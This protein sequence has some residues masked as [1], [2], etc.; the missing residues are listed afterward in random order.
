MIKICGYS[1]EHNK[2]GVC[3]ITNCDK[4]IIMTT[5]TSLLG[6][7]AVEPQV[8]TRWQ[9]PTI[10]DLKKE[11]NKL[12][13]ES[14]EWEERTY[15]WQDRAENLQIVLDKIKEYI[16]NNKYKKMGGYGDNEDEDIEICLFED[17]IWKLEELLEEIE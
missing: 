7:S 2:G 1:C 13:A 5:T 14:T 15:C 4:K 8:L 10:D 16:E 11:I 3:Q 6:G 9:D 17:D 12:T